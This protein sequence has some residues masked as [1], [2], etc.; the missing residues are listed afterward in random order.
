MRTNR[1]CLL[2]GSNDT[3]FEFKS[4][5]K[6]G[7]HVIDSSDTFDMYSCNICHSLF[8]NSLTINDDYFKKYYNTGYY[9]SVAGLQK[10][11]INTLVEK[12]ET[13][14]LSQKQ[15]LIVS[16][17]K[18]TKKKITILDIGCGDGKFLAHLDD[19]KFERFGIEINPEGIKK[20]EDRGLTIYNNDILRIDFGNQR[21][22]VIALWQVIEH[23]ED[24]IAVFK[25]I[26]TILSPDGI[27]ILSTP[28]MLS[29][30]SQFGKH[31]WFH[32]DS[33]RHFI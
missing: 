23:L 11:F 7:R 1:R 17:V 33:P 30:G 13:W 20:A 6:H 18:R 25:K 22:D 3:K 12:L 24:P 15:K 27:V 2:C 8:L 9:D 5:N 4:I 32:L 29:I 14:S 28:N 26:N 10:G 21:F 31:D 16:N 19:K